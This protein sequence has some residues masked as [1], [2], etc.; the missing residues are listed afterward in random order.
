MRIYPRAKDAPM[1]ALLRCPFLGSCLP[2]GSLQAQADFAAAAPVVV[3]V[4]SACELLASGCPAA[5]DGVAAP[6]K[7]A[8]TLRTQ[9][10]LEADYAELALAESMEEEG[11]GPQGAA[12]APEP[13]AGGAAAA[14]QPD[15]FLNYDSV[16]SWLLDEPPELPE[17]DMAFIWGYANDVE[18]D[19]TWVDDL[20]LW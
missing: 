7:K 15:S 6:P 9:A 17:N 12:Q 8:V 14:A 5:T 18:S 13:G 10:E 4:L 19:R 3:N 1:P 2:A 20:E 11:V 16:A